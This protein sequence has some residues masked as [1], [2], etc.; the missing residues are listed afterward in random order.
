[1]HFYVP[2]SEIAAAN[3]S[4]TI[5][6]ITELASPEGHKR[7]LWIVVSSMKETE[8]LEKVEC[9]ETDKQVALLLQSGM[10]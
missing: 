7:S 3:M 10:N 5:A 4:G 8:Q 2:G 9:Q 6:A 1:M